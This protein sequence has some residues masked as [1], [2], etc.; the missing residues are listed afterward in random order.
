MLKVITVIIGGG[1]TTFSSFG[2]ESLNLMRSGEYYS[3]LINIART[4]ISGIATAIAG[5]KTAQIMFLLLR[6]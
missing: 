6:K 4:N 5:F 3:A 2:V 1:Y